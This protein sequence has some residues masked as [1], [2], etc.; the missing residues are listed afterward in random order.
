MFVHRLHLWRTHYKTDDP[1]TAAEVFNLRP[2]A[3]L[4]A[5]SLRRDRGVITTVKTIEL[6][7]RF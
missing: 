4:W 2:D 7:P 1:D 6:P 3:Y 5:S